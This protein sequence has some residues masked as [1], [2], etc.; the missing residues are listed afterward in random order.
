MRAVPERED[1]GVLL[2][3]L[4]HLLE[5]RARAVQ[6]LARALPAEGGVVGDAGAALAER[7]VEEPDAEHD[8]CELVQLRALILG[9][10]VRERL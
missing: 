3:Q 2:A 7:A 10:Q 1:F 6:Q 9:R 8:V 4:T 5:L